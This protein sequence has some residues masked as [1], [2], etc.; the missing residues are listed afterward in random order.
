MIELEFKCVK[1]GKEWTHKVDEHDLKR[2]YQ[3]HKDAP[4]PDAHCSCGPQRVLKF[5]KVK[6]DSVCNRCDD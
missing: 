6:M 5:P 2:Y 1:C 3:M 4:H